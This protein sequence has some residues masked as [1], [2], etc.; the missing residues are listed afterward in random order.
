MPK[1]M[2]KSKKA[3]ED[4]P[5]M[6]KRKAKKLV[7]GI[8]LG[9]LIAGL[10]FTML[11][12]I[13]KLFPNV[14]SD[15]T[16]LGNPDVIWI[17][18]HRSLLSFQAAFK[19]I[20]KNGIMTMV[21]SLL[22]AAAIVAVQMFVSAMVGYALARIDFPGAKLI[23][24]L[25]LLAFLV[26]PQA[27]LLSQYI[28]FKNFDV[29]GIITLLTGSTIDLINKPVTLFLLALFGF[30]VNQSLFV[31][32]FRQFFKNTPKELEEAALIDGCGFHRT[33]FSIM[34]PNAKPAIATVAV[35]GFV[36]NYGDT[37]YT[38][39]FHPDGPYLS[40][41]LTNTF[42]SANENFIL[43][44]MQEWYH[45]PMASSFVFDA[46]KQAGAL[47]YMLPLLIVYFIAQHWLVE[48][49]EN[50]GIVG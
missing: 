36:W 41:I 40:Y 29:L 31:F 14:T 46:V 8:F 44:A 19:F 34:L 13:F 47:I 10:C 32:I 11:Y 22:Y 24:G 25:V 4:T 2:K 38:G 16:D 35:L 6:L 45:L 15:L 50:A 27:L 26:P 7:T 42:Q 43:S 17:P 37:Y 23:F 18:I 1:K 9:S 48:N 30:G 28:H 33:Y 5:Q 39:Y 12:P 49:I 3:K 20:M 21:Y